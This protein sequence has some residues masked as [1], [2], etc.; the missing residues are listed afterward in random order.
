MQS[1]LNMDWSFDDG[2]TQ[3]TSGQEGLN[4]FSMTNPFEDYLYQVT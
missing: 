2:T 1:F 3:C 4:P